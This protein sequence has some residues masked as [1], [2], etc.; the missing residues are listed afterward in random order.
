L[1]V[2]YRSLPHWLGYGGFLVAALV[3]LQ[4]SELFGLQLISV[5]ASSS[6]MHIWLL[7]VGVVAI[8]Q[9]YRLDKV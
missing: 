2:R 3:A 8:L 9:G 5:S 7:A 1:I 4:A 6:A